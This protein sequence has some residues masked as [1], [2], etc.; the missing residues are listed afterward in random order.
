MCVCVCVRGLVM[1][2]VCVWFDPVRVWFDHGFL[3]SLHF[4]IVSVCRFLSVSVG[5]WCGVACD[6]YSD[7]GL[8]S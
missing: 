7:P 6:A 1:S 2:G 8:T 5:F 4:L 3:N